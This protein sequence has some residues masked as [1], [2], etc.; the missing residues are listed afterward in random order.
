M[1]MG[2]LEMKQPSNPDLAADLRDL[3]EALSESELDDGAWLV[4]SSRS[5]VN[6]A[7]ARVL[8]RLR[9]VSTFS[10]KRI[11]WRPAR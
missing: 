10:R 7:S 9:K 5:F 3:V 2:F 6:S 4:D 1:G 8:P 11:P